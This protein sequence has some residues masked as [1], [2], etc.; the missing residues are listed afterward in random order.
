MDHYIVAARSV[1]ENFYR[2]RVLFHEEDERLIPPQLLGFN[3]GDSSFVSAAAV[4]RRG[5]ESLFAWP[6]VRCDSSACVIPAY[7]TPAA[8][9]V[10]RSS[11]LYN[12]EHEE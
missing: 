8:T 11:P 5:H 10:P 9:V 6:E 2:Q 3:P 12:I 1:N 4:D 7:A